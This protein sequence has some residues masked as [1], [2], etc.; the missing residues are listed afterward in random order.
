MA[1]R[2]P[3]HKSQMTP[4]T[5]T[6]KK[7]EKAKG[8]PPKK[9]TTEG[10]PGGPYTPGAKMEKQKATAAAMR[11]GKKKKTATSSTSAGSY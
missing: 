8:G 9:I 2:I 7:P 4:K 3:E 5:S 10:S 6:W 1:D 11:V